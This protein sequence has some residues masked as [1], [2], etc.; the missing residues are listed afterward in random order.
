M[1][2]EETLAAI[3]DFAT[4]AAAG[5]DAQL[6][7][8]AAE[9]AAEAEI[10][11]RAVALAK[12]GLRAASSRIRVG[13]RMWWPNN[14]ET[15]DANEYAPDIRGVFLGGEDKPVGEGKAGAIKDHPRSDVGAY[16]GA[17]IFLLTDGTFVEARYSGRW[18][19]W[20]GASSEWR[21]ELVPMTVAQVAAEYGLDAL[22]TELAGQLERQATA[23]RPT[24]AMQART[25]R[26]RSLAVLLR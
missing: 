7:A 14:T 26:L 3:A 2:T 18:S 8:G 11:A 10:L 9:T 24:A 22:L 17:D 21:A 25:D 1:N 15:A 12:P 19:K 23:E 4:R 5:H 16:E 6:A 20:Q 13:Y